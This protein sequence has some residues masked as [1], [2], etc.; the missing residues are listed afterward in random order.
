[1]KDAIET[2]MNEHQLIL[3]VLASLMTLTEQLEEGTTVPRQ[4]VAGFATFFR[5]FA[6]K[7][8]HGKEEDRLFV[9]MTE[10]GFPREYG[11][12]GVMLSEH[13]AGRTHV[14]MLTE[15]GERSGPLTPEEIHQI[16][17][18]SREYVTLLVAHIQKE[19]NVLYPMAQQ[20]IAPE[21]LASLDAECDAFERDTVGSGEIQRLTNL[22]AQ[23]IQQYPADLESLGTI[24]ACSG[25]HSADCATH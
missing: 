23:L 16:T 13:T 12:V 2:M 22:A 17:F 8:H 14:R 21:D 3:Q 1:M 6:D 9:K 19:D 25:C 15:I 11:P 20:A 4:D 18:Y 24:S 7:I 10:C 5:C